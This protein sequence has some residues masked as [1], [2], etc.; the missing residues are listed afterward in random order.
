MSRKIE[1]AARALT[2][3]VIP[4]LLIGAGISFVVHDHLT[5]GVNMICWGAI[6]VVWSGLLRLTYRR[7][8]QEGQKEGFRQ[9]RV[10]L[11]TS[12][13]E[14][15]LVRRMHPAQWLAAEAERDAPRLVH[16]TAFDAPPDP[17]F[18]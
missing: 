2:E 7:G 3:L 15:V 11:W 8:R 13:H 1:V 16:V 9:A 6:L 18:P 4:A 5:T 12:F 10:E 17:E 14:A